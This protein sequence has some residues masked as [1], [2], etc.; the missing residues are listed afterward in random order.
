MKLLNFNKVLCLSPHFNDVEFG[1]GGT[2]LKYQ[3]TLFTNVLFSTGS[4]NDPVSDKHRWE[5]CENYWKG[6]PNIDLHFAAPLLRMYSEEEWI[7]LLEKQFNL[8]QYDALFLPSEKDT[9][10]E[11]R[12]VHY[13]GMAMTR[14]TAV[15]IIE[16]RT[17]SALDEWVP[18]FYVDVQS[19]VK[20]KLK[21]MKSFRSQQKL[22]FQPTY[23]TAVHGHLPSIKK[24]IPVTEQFK[25][26]VMYPS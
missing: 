25:A 10:Y 24:G 5:E 23:T 9:H 17:P 11:H 20:E 6:I 18:N 26:I 13:I 2:I 12:A 16:Y 7:I 15:S 8:K 22:Y 1:M 19:T 3:N 14:S 4:I 21:R